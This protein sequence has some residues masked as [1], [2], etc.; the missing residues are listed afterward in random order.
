MIDVIG[1]K[2]NFSSCSRRQGTSTTRANKNS[3]KFLFQLHDSQEGIIQEILPDIFAVIQPLFTFTVDILSQALLQHH[4]QKPKNPR[5]RRA[6]PSHSLPPYTSFHFSS[7]HTHGEGEHHRQPH[8]ADPELQRDIIIITIDI[9]TNTTFASW[10]ARPL[11]CT[12]HP[13]CC[14]ICLSATTQRV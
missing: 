7:R 12:F 14:C 2:K 8:T 6:S 9:T 4:G 1:K 10:P 5:A 11:G 13:R 3:Y